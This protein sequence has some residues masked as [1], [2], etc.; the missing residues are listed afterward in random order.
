MRSDLMFKIYRNSF[1]LIIPHIKFSG[2]GSVTVNS[3]FALLTIPSE[4]LNLMDVYSII[5]K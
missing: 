4:N 5:N 3:V 1:A 2:T